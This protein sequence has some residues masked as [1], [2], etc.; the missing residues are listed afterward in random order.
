MIPIENIGSSDNHRLVASPNTNALRDTAGSTI[1]QQGN[2]SLRLEEKRK[3]SELKVNMKPP[4][5]LV[6]RKE[7]KME[8][9][10]NVKI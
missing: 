8:K 10:N 7:P 5:K 3:S 6:F 4:E 9:Y 2:S 1:S